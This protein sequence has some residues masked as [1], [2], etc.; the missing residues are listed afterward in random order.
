MEYIEYLGPI[1]ERQFKIKINIQYLVNCE[2]Y[3]PDIQRLI[4]YERVTQIIDYQKS[5]IISKN[6]I[7]IINGLTVIKFL[8]DV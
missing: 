5:M 1:D 2:L 8:S 6:C 3:R 4:D 7:K